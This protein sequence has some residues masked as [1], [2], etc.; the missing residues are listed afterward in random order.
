MSKKELLLVASRAFSLLLI[1]WAVVELTYL[2]ERLFSLHHHLGQASVV[3]RVVALLFAAIVF[4]R[5]KPG[6]QGIFT[7]RSINDQ[8]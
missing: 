2:P 8:V 1:T 7:E 3:L 5:C 4:W 6:I